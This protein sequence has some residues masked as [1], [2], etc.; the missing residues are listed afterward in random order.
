MA[1]SHLY[2]EARDLKKSFGP[3]KAVSQV[4]LSLS[5]G[6]CLAILGPNGAGK[7]TICEMLEGLQTPDSGTI[8]FFGSQTYGHGRREI[9]E[10]IGVHL[11]ES[12]L[13][14]KYTVLETL[15][16]FASFYKTS[17]PILPLISKLDL[18]DKTHARLEHLSGG[19]R[20]RVYLGC[21]LVN[22]P[23]ILFLDEP[24]T[25]L[26]PKTRRLIWDY[27]LGLKGEGRSLLL[28]T[29]NMEEAAFL[30]DRIGILH[31]GQLIESGTLPELLDRYRNQASSLEEIFFYLSG[32]TIQDA[33]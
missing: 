31:Q 23:R 7:S 6:E 28:T 14:K 3:I 16:L 12:H 32:R 5:R 20:Q 15:E 25:G 18:T 9:L 24:T 11:Q 29:H 19:Q 30:A 17:I 27:L 8:T 1:L 21:A 10:A 2:L 26:D 13:Y 22:D 4:S 33:Q